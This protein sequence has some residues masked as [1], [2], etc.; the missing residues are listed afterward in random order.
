MIRW[1]F[2][3]L[4]ALAGSGAAFPA[5]AFEARSVPAYTQTLASRF[6]NH[7]GGKYFQFHSD[8]PA[9][10]L[11]LYAAFSDMFVELVEQDFF[12]VKTRFPIQAIVLADKGSF[13]HFLRSALGVQMPPEYGIYLPEAALFVTYDGSG[14]GTF[15]HE[16]MH[17]L[18][19]ES[20]PDR[21]AWAIEGIPAFFEKFYGHVQNGRLHVQWGYQNPWRIEK[22]GPKLKHLKLDRIVTGSEDTSEKRLVT[23]YLSQ[24]GKLKTFLELVQ[25]NDRR[26]FRTHLEAAFGKPLKEI[27]ADWKNYLQEIESNRNLIMQLPTSRLF[28]TPDQYRQFA[29]QF[30]L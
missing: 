3:L 25:A 23:V 9:Q 24:R 27:E 14:L 4:L 29:V 16:I 17:P 6:A 22:L 13:K 8:L 15:T 5:N 21:P 20:L 2:A 18:V 11:A 7:T 1:L 30:G 12:R 26:G 19:E 10:R 28:D